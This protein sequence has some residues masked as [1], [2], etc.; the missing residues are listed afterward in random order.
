[1]AVPVFSQ[2]PAN[3]GDR[4]EQLEVASQCLCDAFDIDASTEP[5]FSLAEVYEAG[6]AALVRRVS[7]RRSGSV[8][9]GSHQ[10]L[11]LHQPLILDA[12]TRRLVMPTR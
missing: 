1:M 5:E 12:R 4:A 8:D 10:L 3:A 7:N 9:R 6:M 11:L 2:D